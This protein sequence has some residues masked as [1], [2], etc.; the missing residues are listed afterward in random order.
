MKQKISFDIK[1]LNLFFLA[2]VL[3]LLLGTCVYFAVSLHVDPVA[4]DIK[5]D[6]V[7]K[8]LFILNDK[9][10]CLFA[11]LL[12]YYPVSKRATALQVAGNTGAIYETIGRVDKIDAVYKEQGTIPYT[13][14]VEKLC[15]TDIPYIINISSDN[16]CQMADIM[17]GIKVFVPSPIDL[18]DA[19]G[20]RFLLPSGAVLLDGDKVHT[21]MMYKT[22]EE[23]EEDIQERR[24]QAF[25]A[26]LESLHTQRTSLFTKKA[27][28]YT[29]HLFSSNISNESLKL[30]LSEIS[31]IDAEQLAVQ[32]IMGTYRMVDEKRLLFPFY[33]GQLVKESVKRMISSLI[34]TGNQEHSRV[35]VLE[36]KNGTTTQGLARNTSVLMQSVGY[37][38]LETGNAERQDY[39]KTFIINHI[40]DEEAGKSLA[41]FIHCKEIVVD[42]VIGQEAGFDVNSNVDF[43]LV[44]GK[45]FDGR[46]VR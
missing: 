7:L 17:G 37:D 27:F 36:I 18:T 20:E 26:F 34:T 21:F 6:Q 38:V 23:T 8:V 12:A 13:K 44:L 42:D 33:E 16:F 35:Y 24:Q 19:Q 11:E 5:N 15:S 25:S 46:Y 31:N 40:A 39:E 43:T 2:L 4:Q 28:N 22:P 45:D 41:D 29:R 10:D 1:H 3:F 14:E 32:Q 30:L 9:D